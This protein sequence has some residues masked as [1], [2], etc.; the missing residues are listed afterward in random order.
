VLTGANDDGALGLRRIA[1][2][3]GYTIVQDPE[4]AEGSAMP[5]AAL[6]LVPRAR[7]L[8]LERIASHLVT[9]APLRPPA[10]HRTQVPYA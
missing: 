6:R 2:R 7:V 4:T 9:I 10:Q 8:P 3:G 1:D 5:R